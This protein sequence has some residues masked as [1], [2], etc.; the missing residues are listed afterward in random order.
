MSSAPYGRKKS[1]EAIKRAGMSVEVYNNLK[2]FIYSTF[3]DDTWCT[4]TIE[5][6]IKEMEEVTEAFQLFDVEQ[7]GTIDVKEIKAA[8][9]AL[10]FQVWDDTTVTNPANPTPFLWLRFKVNVPACILLF[11]LSSHL[12]IV[13]LYGYSC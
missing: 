8:F 5:I 3:S 11:S 12:F 1:A 6:I 7:K 2:Y 13:W 4:I 10:G 9:R